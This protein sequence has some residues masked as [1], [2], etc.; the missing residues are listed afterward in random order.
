MTNTPEETLKTLGITVESEFVPFSQSRNNI[1]DTPTLNWLVTVKRNGKHVI[2]TEYSA[3]C[4]HCPGYNAKVPS[5][6]DHPDSMFQKEIVR[7]ECEKGIEQH[8]GPHGSFMNKTHKVDGR[9]LPVHIE[10]DPV[11]VLYCLV[12]DSDV[13]DSGGFE[14]WAYDFGYDTD[15]RKAEAIYKECIET[16]LKMRAGFS[17]SELSLLRETFQDY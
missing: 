5:K 2:T 7:V 6:W 1:G 13:L 9:S 17:E 8:L 3:G 14:N 16:A 4:A 11:N 10:P 12:L 15:S